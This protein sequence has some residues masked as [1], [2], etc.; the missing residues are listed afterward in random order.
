[1]DNIMGIA[2]MSVNMSSSQLQQDVSVSVMKKAMN[3]Q[4]S[5]AAE[6][7]QTLQQTVQT[8]PADP[9]R[10]LDMKI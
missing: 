10:L 7:I 4:E 6:L 1:M 2:A 9:T 5:Q 3:T 8:P